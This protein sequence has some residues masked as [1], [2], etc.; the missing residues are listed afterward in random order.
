[1]RSDQAVREFMCRE[2]FRTFQPS[3]E[4]TVRRPTH[5]QFQPTCEPTALEGDDPTI[6]CILNL[7]SPNSRSKRD[8]FYPRHRVGPTHRPG[9]AILLRSANDQLSSGLQ[10]GG[11]S[12]VIHLMA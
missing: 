2:P 8:S 1:M 11:V 12:L 4:L 9:P 10:F 7:I 3:A 5:L 6:Y